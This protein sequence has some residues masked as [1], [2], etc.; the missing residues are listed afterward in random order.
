MWNFEDL[1]KDIIAHVNQT[2]S[3][4]SPLDRIDASLKCRVEEWLHP[5]YQVLCERETGLTDEEAEHL[6]LRR[7]AAIWRI[8]ESRQPILAACW[9][10]RRNVEQCYE[11]GEYLDQKRQGNRGRGATS[12]L[13]PV[14]SVLELIKFEAA[15]KFD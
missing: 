11:C 2:I 14:L 4:A 6:G 10:C 3:D 7:A 5:A 8:R 1:R 15:L 12:G 13:Q 9:S